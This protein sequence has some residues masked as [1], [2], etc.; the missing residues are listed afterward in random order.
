[1][2]VWALT[3]CIM[4][5]GLKGKSHHNCAGP[6]SRHYGVIYRQSNEMVRTGGERAVPVI[7]PFGA[8]TWI[9]MVSPTERWWENGLHVREPLKWL[10]T[11]R[12][13]YNALWPIVLSS[14]HRR[15]KQEGPGS[16]FLAKL[17]VSSK[18]K[19]PNVN[20]GC[21]SISWSIFQKCPNTSGL[22]VFR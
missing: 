2:C 15:H 1:M 18:Q 7:S 10:I 9:V 19:L 4:K 22:L 16:C 6:K 21:N 14:T 8:L 20:N 17:N 3:Y 12:M 11:M 13:E 5:K